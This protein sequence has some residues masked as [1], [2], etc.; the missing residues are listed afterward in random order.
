[1]MDINLVPTRRCTNLNCSECFHTLEQRRSTFITSSSVIEKQ[2]AELNSIDKIGTICLFGG[3]LLELPSDYL[4]SLINLALN[5]TDKVQL[6]SNLSELIPG[7]LLPLL[8]RNKISIC[9]SY[10]GF[11]SKTM[12][13][14]LRMLGIQDVPVA[15]NILATHK[16]LSDPIYY[17][18]TLKHM[19]RSVNI[20]SVDIIPVG[21]TGANSGIPSSD[22]YIMSLT[23]SD[24]NNHP[25][26][27][28]SYNLTLRRMINHYLNQEGIVR[29]E[30]TK[31]VY[32]IDGKVKILEHKDGIEYF[33]DYLNQN[34]EIDRDIYK[35][36]FTP[37]E[38][39]ELYSTLS[40]FITSEIDCVHFTNHL[41]R[42]NQEEFNSFSPIYLR[43][44]DIDFTYIDSY[45]MKDS[46]V[47]CEYPHKIICVLILYYNILRARGVDLFR[48]NL[49]PFRSNTDNLLLGI[50]DRLMNYVKSYQL[51]EDKVDNANC[52]YLLDYIHT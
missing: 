8:A 21:K 17:L 48:D 3:E 26:F 14:N 34:L 2:L 5:Y 11:T 39:I 37:T 4:D 16:F 52:K 45:F 24:L 9:F 25:L 30:N 44:D 36:E 43:Y 10:Y 50:D 13:R 42:L 32:L 12:I 35:E 6:V 51:N 22:E 1:M 31:P 15:V 49:Y 7:S 33:T 18:D 38:N 28:S 41:S 40:G 29:F 23:R 20:Q 46:T 19:T 47:G 27:Q